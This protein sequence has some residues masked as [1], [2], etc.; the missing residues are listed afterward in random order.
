M[1]DY[2]NSSTRII[3]YSHPDQ[4]ECWLVKQQENSSYLIATVIDTNRFII[5]KNFTGEWLARLDWS[6]EKIIVVEP[7]N[8][9][10]P[11]E[12]RTFNSA[13]RF[14]DALLLHHFIKTS[15]T[16]VKSN[17]LATPAA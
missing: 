14:L 12:F 8:V 3:Q 4:V 11:Y 7:E 2:R 13:F 1:I 17:V 9:M 6:G 16:P 10:S 15:E 5:H